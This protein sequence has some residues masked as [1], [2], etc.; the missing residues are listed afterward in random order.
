MKDFMKEKF[1]DTVQKVLI[2]VIQDSDE[3]KVSNGHKLHLFY[4]CITV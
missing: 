2:V 3:K 1:V 4:C